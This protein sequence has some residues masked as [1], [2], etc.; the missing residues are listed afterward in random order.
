MKLPTFGTIR[1]VILVVVG[2]VDFNEVVKVVDVAGLSFS[3]HPYGTNFPSVSLMVAVEFLRL[4]IIV[5]V[6]VKI[7][8]GCVQAIICSGFRIV[9]SD[10]LVNII[11]LERVLVRKRVLA[12]QVTVDTELFIR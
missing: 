5:P 7:D 9:V 12:I 2:P 11:P 4:V 6:S 1:N 10:S 3:M 8:I